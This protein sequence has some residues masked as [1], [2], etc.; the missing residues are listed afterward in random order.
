MTKEHREILENL[1]KQVDK[2]LEHYCKCTMCTNVKNYIAALNLF[3]QARNT[4]QWCCLNIKSDYDYIWEVDLISASNE[5]NVLDEATINL[6][7]ADGIYKTFTSK[8]EH[9]GTIY[10]ASNESLLLATLYALKYAIA[11]YL[12][13]N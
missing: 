12:T 3:S 9:A 8:K 4:Q 6:I 1:L 5:I 13:K 11:D 10:R 2:E 7:N